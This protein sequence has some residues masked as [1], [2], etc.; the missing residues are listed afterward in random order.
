MDMSAPDL[1]N[2]L[3]DDFTAMLGACD[4]EKMVRVAD[5]AQTWP[6]NWK[7]ANEAFIEGYHAQATHPQLIPNVDTDYAQVDLYPN[8]HKWQFFPFT[9]PMTPY[10]D[11]ISEERS[12]ENKLFQRE[13][14]VADADFPKTRD[15]GP[16]EVVKGKRNR[17]SGARDYSKFTDGQLIDDWSLSF[18]QGVTCNVHPEGVLVQ[19]WRP[20]LPIR[21]NANTSCGSMPCRGYRNCYSIWA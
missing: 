18:F 9:E 3:N 12:E 8:G 21:F 13:A 16:Q 20:H 14:G 11:E 4:L 17:A 7:T 19:A 2:Y 5:V 15:G 1:V 10:L 6:V